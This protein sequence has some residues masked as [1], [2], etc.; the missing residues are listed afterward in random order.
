M[1]YFSNALDHPLTSR[2][3][4]FIKFLKKNHI[5]AKVFDVSFYYE[6]QGIL[7]FIKRVLSFPSKIF[8]KNYQNI[9]IPSLPIIG[10]RTSLIRPLLNS[11]YSF[12][13]F[14]LTRLVSNSIDYNVIISA[15]PVS[16]LI[17]NFAKKS[18]TFIVYEDLDYFEDIKTGRLLRLMISFLEKLAIKRANL[19]VSV[20]KPLLKRAQNLNQNC[21][22]IPNGANLENFPDPENIQRDPVI[23][24]A[25]TLDE[26]AGVK[27]VVEAFPRIKKNFPWLKMHI[28]G[29][30]KEKKSLEKLVESLSLKENIFFLGRIPYEKLAQI[31][32][33]LSIGIAMFK[34]TNAGKFAS[35]LKLFDYMGA[36]LPIISTNIGDIGRILTESNAGIS[37]NWNI[38]EFIK[39]V[40]ILATDQKL[41]QKCHKNG[42]LY[43]KNFDWDTLF[44]ELLQELNSRIQKRTF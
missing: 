7:N 35:P 44:S 23:V 40:E 37:I 27:L 3:N 6:N 42:L 2:M 17:S 4:F 38:E 39:S 9:I 19:V 8:N 21:I 36:G 10:N 1:L 12:V 13:A 25:G 32:C 26:W 31:L 22:L 34:P 29:D 14:I 41:W 43:V 18:N 28:I 5:N 20:S 11:L 15:D 30:G 24:Y 16:A 33:N